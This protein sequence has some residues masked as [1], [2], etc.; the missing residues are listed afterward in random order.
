VSKK[1]FF[2][3]NTKKAE[4]IGNNHDAERI[5]RC[6]AYAVQQNFLSDASQLRKAIKTAVEHHFG[7]HGECGTWCGVKP[8]VG[9]E[10]AGQQ[11]KYRNKEV[12][13]GKQC[14]TKA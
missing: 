3:C 2:L 14:F 10:R 7:D 1:F 5:K 8:L 4:C 13:G 6:V 12:K 11:L 9:D